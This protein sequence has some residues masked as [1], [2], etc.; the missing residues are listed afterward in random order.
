LQGD[1]QRLE[2]GFNFGKFGIVT[3][4]QN[5]DG[6]LGAGQSFLWNSPQNLDLY[7]ADLDEPSVAA[8][9]NI[10]RVTEYFLRLDGV[11]GDS[12]V[13][14]FEGWCELDSFSFG[15]L[16]SGTTQLDAGGG[17]GKVSLQ[18]LA[19]TLSGNA[20]LAGFLSMVSMADVVTALEVVGISNDNERIYELTLNDVYTS[21]VKEVATQNDEPNLNVT[22]GYNQIGVIATHPNLSGPNSQES[23]GWDDVS[24]QTID[25]NSLDKATP[26]WKPRG[27]TRT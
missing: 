16:Q 9:L 10:A 26:F 5:S 25:P 4:A 24:S 7:P 13:G 18:D 6:S 2:V 12:T 15:Q 27:P 1:K 23:Y 11:A 22:F 8:L 14:N 3:T 21:T 17:A 19:V 20:G